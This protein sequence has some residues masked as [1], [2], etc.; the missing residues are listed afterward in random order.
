M[1]KYVHSLS[2]GR[3]LYNSTQILSSASIH[4]HLRYV[5]YMRGKTER[6]SIHQEEQG[7]QGGWNRR[8]K[9]NMKAEKYTGFPL[10]QLPT[11]KQSPGVLSLN[12]L[13]T[14]AAKPFIVT[15][16]VELLQPQPYSLL[17]IHLPLSPEL[18]VNSSKSRDLV[19]KYLPNIP[20]KPPSQQS[21][22]FVRCG[23][24]HRDRKR[25]CEW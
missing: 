4:P 14:E 17:R 20:S 2:G 7:Q 13:W 21:G 12:S 15:D 9:Q 8:K 16:D 11:T 5:K 25:D 23:V 18:R 22:A 3:G 1:G 6:L 19:P 24:F 10:S